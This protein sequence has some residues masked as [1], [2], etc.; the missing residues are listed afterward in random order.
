MRLPTFYA[1]S[2][3]FVQASF[4]T[5]SDHRYERRDSKL[6]SFLDDPLE[7]I[8]LDERR[9]Q[10]DLD[11]RRRRRQLLDGSKDHVFFASRLDLGKINVRVGSE[12]S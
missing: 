10:C 2:G 4:S 9:A 1:G 12:I 7:V 3:G 5:R 11:G 8:E 6:G